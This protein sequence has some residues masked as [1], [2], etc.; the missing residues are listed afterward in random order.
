M[1]VGRRAARPG[2]PVEFS[3]RR[4]YYSTLLY[5]TLLYSTLLYSTLL[6]ST[7]LYS[8]LL[9]S[10][11]LSSPLILYSSTLPSGPFF[12]LRATATPR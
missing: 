9:Y 11:L 2:P 10:T 7:L 12:R 8:T 5:S 3:R 1:A 6:Y 4:L